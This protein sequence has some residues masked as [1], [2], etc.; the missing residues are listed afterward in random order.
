MHICKGAIAI[1]TIIKNMM[2]DKE[3]IPLDQQRLLFAGTQLE[4]DRTLTE[5]NIQQESTLHLVLRLRGG[6]MPTYYY[7]DSSLLDSRFDYR[8]TDFK[9][10]V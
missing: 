4:N 5:Y 1:G 2:Q 8:R 7:A 6:G 10:I 3:G 9:C